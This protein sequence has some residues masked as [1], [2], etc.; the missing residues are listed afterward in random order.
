MKLAVLSGKGGT[1]K[2]FVAVNLAA[3]ADKAVYID[4]DVEEPN[5]RLFLKPT[6]TKETVVTT[7]IPQFDGTKCTA[8][9]KCVDFCRFNALV[10]VKDKPMVFTEICHSCGGCPLVCPEGAITEIEKPVGVVETGQ[11]AN[12]HVVTGCMNLGEASGIPVINAA[13]SQDLK[14]SELT[15]IDCPPGTA[16]SAME[17]ADYADYCVIVVE[18]TAFGLHNFKMVYELVTV[19]N[20]PCG[21]IINKADGEYHEVKKFCDEHNIPIL[22]RIPYSPKLASLGAGAQV[23]S[24]YDEETAKLFRD[25]LTDIKKEVHV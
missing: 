1:G 13:L 6:D 15:V 21:V 3:V 19:L 10:L 22:C 9:R 8:C 2:T 11:S 20:K 17:S 24:L 16:C 7:L 4:C 23:A 14:D 5:G 12:V 25:L 18:P